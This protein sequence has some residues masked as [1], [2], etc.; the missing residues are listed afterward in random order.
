LLPCPI[1]W[2]SRP[3]QTEILVIFWTARKTKGGDSSC[4]P[5]RRRGGS[6][7]ISQ[8]CR[9]CCG[10]PERGNRLVAISLR[11]GSTRL[12]RSQ[13]ECLKSCAQSRL[14]LL[15]WVLEPSRINFVFRRSGLQMYSLLN[16]S[17]L[18]IGFL[19]IVLAPLTLV[20]DTGPGGAGWKLLTFLCCAFAAWFFIFP[21]NLLIAVVAWL[22]AW[23]VAMAMRMSFN[24]RRA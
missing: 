13:N 1:S 9:S 17:V 20:L 8:S 18:I 12:K 11:R 2:S 14:D 21:S 7:R 23:A 4:S 16:D 3:T 10:K 6:R 22:L 24:R 5:K 15:A 19:A